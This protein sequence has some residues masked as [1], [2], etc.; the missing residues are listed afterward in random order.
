MGPPSTGWEGG[1]VWEAA[2]ARSYQGERLVPDP[3]GQKGGSWGG[4]AHRSSVNCEVT[5]LILWPFF[6]SVDGKG[7][8]SWVYLKQRLWGQDTIPGTEGGKL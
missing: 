6:L 2:K 4:C 7:S 5:E 1:R 3:G 8:I